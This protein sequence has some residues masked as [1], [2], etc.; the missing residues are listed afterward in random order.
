MS[1]RAISP[2]GHRHAFFPLPAGPGPGHVEFAQ[3]RLRFRAA[4]SS[5]WRSASSASFPRRA[6]SST[7]RW[8][9][10]PASWPRRR[11]RWPRPGPRQP[12]L[13]AIGITNQRETTV[14]W[15]RR[16]GEPL[17][18]AIVWQ[19]RRTAPACARLAARLRSMVRER[20]A[21][22]STPTF[23]APSWPG[24]ST[25]PR[26][27]GGGRTR[28][29]GLRHHRQLAAWQLTGGAVHATD[30]SNASRTM[31]FD[32]HRNRWDDELLALFDIPRAVLPAVHPS[33]HCYGHNGP[34]CSARRSCHRRHRRRPAGRAVRPG[35]LP[36]AWPRTPTA[37]AASC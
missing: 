29:T 27:D 3:H 4:G 1:R 34:T 19:D 10:G 7:T 35:L 12:I 26:R 13:P 23:P 24:Y 14:V 5:P 36:P 22:C 18:N 31:L 20:P 9:S 15:N 8:K 30:V 6:G 16:S 21:W 28:R 2:A 11:R 17:C 37:R 32:I 33:S 25:T